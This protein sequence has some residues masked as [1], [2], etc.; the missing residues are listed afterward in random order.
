MATRLLRAQDD[1]LA[2]FQVHCIYAL[3]HRLLLCTAEV[4]QISLA[5]LSI[6]N[7]TKVITKVVTKG[8]HYGSD[9]PQRYK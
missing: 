1:E 8:L 4:K 9:P 7:D 6:P 3:K 2:A 5:S